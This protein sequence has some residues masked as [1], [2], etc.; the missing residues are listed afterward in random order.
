MRPETIIATCLANGRI[1]SNVKDGEA[2]VWQVFTREFRELSFQVWN[3]DLDDHFATEFIRSKG[4]PS[5]VNV[6]RAIEE[7]FPASWSV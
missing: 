6:K 3:R 5:S 7:F 2:L 4:R 1:V